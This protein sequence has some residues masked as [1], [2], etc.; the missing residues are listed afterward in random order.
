[1]S[2]H[3]HFKGIQANTLPT[4]V[5]VP[6]SHSA[7]QHRQ[8]LAVVC[9]PLLRNLHP[10]EPMP[11]ALATTS[12]PRIRCRAAEIDSIG[13]AN[14]CL[15]LGAAAPAALG[16]YPCAIFAAATMPN[17]RRDPLLMLARSKALSP[18]RQVADEALPKT[19]LDHYLSTRLEQYH[20]VAASIQVFHICKSNKRRQRNT[21]REK[22]QKKKKK[23]KKKKTTIGSTVLLDSCW[24]P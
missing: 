16:E 9:V 20:F 21:I 15:A 12:S 22:N 23:K 5:S 4:T 1:M 2:K 17:T 19:S 11:I 18:D 8:K 3:T 14:C 24:R 13:L 7:S 6:L 10:V